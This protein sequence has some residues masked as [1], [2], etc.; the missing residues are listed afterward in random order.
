MYVGI[1][2][3]RAGWFVVCLYAKSKFKIDIFKDIYALWDKYFNAKI[4]LIDIPIGLPD[5]KITN[6]QCDLEARKI[7]GPKRGA[8]VFP[9]PSRLAFHA[10]DYR[11]A[12][13]LNR[14][15]IKKGLSYQVLNIIPK[16]KEVDDFVISNSNAK[17]IFRESHPEI[18][19]FSMKGTP[20]KYSKK[21]PDGIK[22]RLDILNSINKKSEEIFN[23]SLS[24]FKRKYLVRDDILDGICLAL[25]AKGSINSL[26]TIPKNPQYDSRGIRME[27]VYRKWKNKNNY[28]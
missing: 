2:G 11:Q 23:Y 10:N 13:C 25:A 18:C 7:L 21:K 8:S 14:K 3:C 20:L 26:I 15:T 22:E 4:I 17:G 5:E 24:K 12:N 1:D 19:F 6:R 27:I 9:T 28:V 16:I